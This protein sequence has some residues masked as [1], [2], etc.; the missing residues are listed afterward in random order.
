M[1]DPMSAGL[2]TLPSH[3]DGQERPDDAFAQYNFTV[4]ACVP[5]HARLRT[6]T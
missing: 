1:G 5:L 6:R 4:P 3:G 2:V